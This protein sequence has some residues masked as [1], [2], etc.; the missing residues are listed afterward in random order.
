MALEINWNAE[1]N[2]VEVRADNDHFVISTGPSLA[3][4]HVDAMRLCK[5]TAWTLPTKRQLKTIGRN[6]GKINQLLLAHGGYR[7][8]KEWHN[9]K[10]TDGTYASIV[11]TGYGTALYESI[12]A[13]S[14]VRLVIDM[15]TINKN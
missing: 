8:Y 4:S 11:N 9:T 13:P 7:I 6:L 5:G 3:M 1:H 10:D 14:H 15:N 2:G 12:H